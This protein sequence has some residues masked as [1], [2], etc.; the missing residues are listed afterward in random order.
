MEKSNSRQR[1]SKKTQL[2]FETWKTKGSQNFEITASTFASVLLFSR[3]K[4]LFKML[5]IAAGK[6]LY[7]TTSSSE[8]TGLVKPHRLDAA[9]SR[10]HF[11]KFIIGK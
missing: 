6:Q 8:Y 11:T 10:Q 1:L 4:I 7:C 5:V 9:K 3:H 2:T